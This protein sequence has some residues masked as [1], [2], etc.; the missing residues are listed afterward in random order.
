MLLQQCH[1]NSARSLVIARRTKW[2][3]VLLFSLCCR[4]PHKLRETAK[5][6]RIDKGVSDTVIILF[7]SSRC[8]VSSIPYS[9]HTPL[10]EILGIHSADE[11]V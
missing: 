2:N 7:L 10:L 5:V 11:K 8:F 1:P 6:N 3:S 9:S 4:P